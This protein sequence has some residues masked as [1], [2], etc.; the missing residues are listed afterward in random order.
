M[1]RAAWDPLREFRLLQRDMNEV[2][3]RSGRRRT[4]EFPPMNI[5]ANNEGAILTTEIPGIDPDKLEINVLGDTLTLRGERPEPSSDEGNTFHR[6]ER[7]FGPFSR[8]VQLA[9]RVDP[10]KVAANYAEGQL[11]ILVSRADED[12]PRSIRVTTS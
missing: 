10:S 2:L 12:R 4:A 9:F 1:M 7:G 11:E 5:W 8:T 3:G 6:R